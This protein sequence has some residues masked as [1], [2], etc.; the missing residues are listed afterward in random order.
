MLYLLSGESPGCRSI[1]SS[2]FLLDSKLLPHKIYCKLIPFSFSHHLGLS[3]LTP[4]DG[5]VG[6]FFLNLSIPVCESHIFLFFPQNISVLTLLMLP[7]NI[8]AASLIVST[9]LYP[10]TGIAHDSTR[11][12]LCPWYIPSCFG[13]HM[14]LM[15]LSSFKCY[16]FPWPCSTLPLFSYFSHW[17]P[18]LYPL[19]ARLNSLCN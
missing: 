1:F 10:T 16:C 13:T 18:F 7:Q 12:G 9:F 3:F 19:S 17:I 5:F 4:E 2:V 6:N 8:L 14:P 11:V 15:T